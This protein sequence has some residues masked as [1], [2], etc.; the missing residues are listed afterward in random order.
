MAE[1]CRYNDTAQIWVGNHKLFDVDEVLLVG[2][3]ER[4][5]IPTNPPREFDGPASWDGQLFGLRSSQLSEL[6][7][8]PGFQLHLTNDRSGNAVLKTIEDG[9]GI[10]W[11]SGEIPFDCPPPSED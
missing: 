9:V 6:L 3:V 1:G 11:G 7:K 2:Y 8:L 10:I 5:V 4:I